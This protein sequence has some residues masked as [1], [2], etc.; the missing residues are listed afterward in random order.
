[1]E[2]V[3]KAL[4]VISTIAK[5]THI[6]HRERVKAKYTYVLYINAIKY[7]VQWCDVDKCLRLFCATIS[8]PVAL[9]FPMKPKLLKP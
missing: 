3:A 5:L 8:F 1:M 7:T 4:D 2:N 9:F 6:L